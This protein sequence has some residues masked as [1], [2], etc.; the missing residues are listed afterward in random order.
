VKSR[1]SGARGE[2]S[3]EHIFK[4][5][6]ALFRRRGIGQTTMRDVA[7]RAGVALGAAYYYFRS[8][9]DIVR[10]YY[11]RLGEEHGRRMAAVLADEKDLR[12]RIGAAYHVAIDL[13]ARDRKIIAGLFRSVGEVGSLSPF[14]KSSAAFRERSIAML[15]ET[16]EP[17]ALPEP[18][19]RMAATALWGGQMATILYLVHDD[20]KDLEK[21]RALVDGVLDLVVPLLPHL[22]LALPALSQLG[23]VLEEAGLLPTVLPKDLQPNGRTIGR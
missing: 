20:S 22:P 15:G 11:E 8:K 13:L 9:D 6:L 16:L 5:A 21:T 18:I 23:A 12:K 4:T 2:K 3:R 14:S 19:H 10:A 1:E 17:A 7:D